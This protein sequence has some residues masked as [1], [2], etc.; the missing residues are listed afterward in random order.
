[1][2]SPY[3]QKLGM[4]K[5]PGWPGGDVVVTVIV[6]DPASVH[7]VPPA[8]MAE[9]SSLLGSL[10]VRVTA[11]PAL[12]DP[13][14]KRQEAVV[15][16]CCPTVTVPHAI[17]AGATVAVT[18]VPEFG[19]LKPA[20]ATAVRVVVPVFAASGLNCAVAIP[21]PPLNTAGAT[22]VPTDGLELVIVTEGMKRPLRLANGNPL[23]VP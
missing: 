6:A 2:P 15:S 18:L 10:L 1:M 22:T 20:G 3:T 19:V 16:R 17:P 23:I 11:S 8:A 12:G 9:N 21:S 5:R 14:L 4:M 7:V 13:P